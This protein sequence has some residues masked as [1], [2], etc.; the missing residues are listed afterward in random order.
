MRIELKRPDLSNVA[1]EP[2]VF[3]FESNHFSIPGDRPGP[4]VVT[5]CTARTLAHSPTA[6]WTRS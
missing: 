6:G 1:F 5:N 3:A 2:V 4:N